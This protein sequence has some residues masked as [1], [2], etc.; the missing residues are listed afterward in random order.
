VFFQLNH[1][2]VALGLDTPAAAIGTQRAGS[3]TRSQD[4]SPSSD[5]S[6]PNEQ[7]IHRAGDTGIYATGTLQTPRSRY[8]L[9]AGT[10]IAAALLTGID[11]SLPGEVMASVTE[12]VYDTVSGRYLL[13]PQGSRLIGEYDSEV[14]FGQRRVL[15]V[16]TRLIM[17]D[18]SSIVL[19]R[20]PASDSEGRAGLEDRVDRHWGRIFAGAAISTLLGVNAELVSRNRNDG[21]IVVATRN[22]AQDSVNQ[23]G[24]ELTRKN[25][26][27]QPTLT[28]RPGFPIRILVNRDLVLR[29]VDAAQ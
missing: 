2:A 9:L 29:E 25:I 16:W 19:D 13:V 3:D 7:F 26:E 10:V 8:E 18:G 24:Q 1:R 21:S 20:L 22:S 15:L 28:I 6:S 27:L 17:P 23:L 11:S 4:G 14:A 12:P 5:R